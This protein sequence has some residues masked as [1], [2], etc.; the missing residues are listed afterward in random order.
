MQAPDRSQKVRRMRRPG[1]TLIE[2][3]VVIIILGILM[4][5]AIPS[6]LGFKDQ[7]NKRTAQANVRAAILREAD[8]S[9]IV[10]MGAA[11]PTAG[12]AWGDWDVV[13]GLSWESCQSRSAQGKIA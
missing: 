3:L 5:I 4:A 9:D 1:F 13:M 11:A 6:Y 10:V 2:L 12:G 7:A 8:H